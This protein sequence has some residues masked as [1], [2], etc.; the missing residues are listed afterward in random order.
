MSFIQL[1]LN[2][3][4]V[5]KKV[6]ALRGY[7]PDIID[8]SLDDL[9]KMYE[10]GTMENNINEVFSF[11]VPHRDIPDLKLHI[12]YYNLPKKGEHKSTKVST[13]AFCNNCDAFYEEEDINYEDNCLYIINEKLSDSIKEGINK[14]NLVAREQLV[15]DEIDD[16]NPK[17]Q[18]FINDKKTPFNNKHLH[19]IHIIWL[20]ILSLDPINHD[21]VPQHRIIKNEEHINNICSRI[22]CNINQLQCIQS[23][24]DTMSI[25]L[26]GCP[27]DICE[28]KRINKRSG[29]SYNYR[30]CV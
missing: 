15:N 18:A 26:E 27:G 13:K 17:I 24:S 8:Y 19:N 4:N 16:L 1:I 23:Y 11:S 7:S 5:L 29:I 9:E 3:R 6:V 2:T 20:K 30:L 12:K 28:I 25:L 22:N 14:Y 10:K 21:L